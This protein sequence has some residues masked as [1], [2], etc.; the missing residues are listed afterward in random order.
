MCSER[1]HSENH[2]HFSWLSCV[3]LCTI[4]L[5]ASIKIMCQFLGLKLEEMKALSMHCWGT[6]G[7]GPGSYQSQGSFLII[8]ETQLSTQLMHPCTATPCHKHLKSSSRAL[9]ILLVAFRR[10]EARLLGCLP[11]WGN[12]LYTSKPFRLV[13]K[14]P[15]YSTHWNVAV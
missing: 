15:Y 14:H 11:S 5:S 12:Q 2:R 9:S 4:L 8:S 1:M 7:G 6:T 13:T 3:P 10:A